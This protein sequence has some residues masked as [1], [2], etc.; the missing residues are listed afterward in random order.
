MEC[1]RILPCVIAAIVKPLQ[2]G[3]QTDDATTYLEP[4]SDHRR[5]QARA[6]PGI[7]PDQFESCILM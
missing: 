6:Y 5:L 3:N 2:L 1:G 7:A 4:S